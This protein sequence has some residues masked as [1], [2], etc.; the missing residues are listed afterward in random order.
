M[1]FRK[2]LTYL[3]VPLFLSGCADQLTKNINQYQ[4][5]FEA[6][7]NDFSTYADIKIEAKS[8]AKHNAE[9]DEPYY[10]ST[11][12]IYLTSESGY[13][14]IY[15]T[16]D[17]PDK[18]GTYKVRV[19]NNQ[20]L[21]YIKDEEGVYKEATYKFDPNQSGGSALGDVFIQLGT[22]L[23]NVKWRYESKGYY[24]NFVT[25]ENKY[26]FILEERFNIYGEYDEEGRIKKEM[27]EL[28]YSSY[29]VYTE[30][31]SIEYRTTIP[32]VFVETYYID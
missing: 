30:K 6:Y 28:H 11:S 8:F 14:V 17:I 31:V 7:Q 18:S 25:E 23:Q 26:S 19:F 1:R 16:T 9:E 10:L 3:I 4:K 29:I 32:D 2:A 5:A 27:I 15:F 21:T 13:R 20:Y 12:L 22:M 24:E